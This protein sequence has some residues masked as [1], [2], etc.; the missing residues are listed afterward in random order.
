MCNLKSL[1][2]FAA[3]HEL[4]ENVSVFHDVHDLHEFEKEVVRREKVQSTGIGRGVAVAH[5]VCRDAHDIILGLGIS[6]EG[7]DFESIDG[8]PVHL[9]FLIANPSNCE[10]EYLLVLSALVKLVRNN[11]FRR[12]LLNASSPEKVQSLLNNAFCRQATEE[13]REYGYTS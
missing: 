7:I 2:K 13:K 12:K 10:E 4:L 1:E 6:D 9:L 11:A 3:I 8:K 5:G